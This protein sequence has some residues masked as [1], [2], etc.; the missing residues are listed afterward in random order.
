MTDTADRV[1]RFAADLIDS[2]A[3]EGAR[4]SRSAKQQL[5]HWARVGRAVSS[6]H[7]AARRKVEAALAGDIPLRE[8]TAEEGAVFDAEIAASIEESLARAD[9]GKTLAARGITTVALDENGDIVQYRPDGS[10]AA[11]AQQQ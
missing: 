4:Q 5:D 1:T 11:L 9:Y 2:A 6:R 7:S 10:T 3:A 8:L